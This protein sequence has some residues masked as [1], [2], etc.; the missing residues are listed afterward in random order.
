MAIPE[1]QLDIWSHQ[2]SVAG[3]AATYN[4]LKNTLNDPSA[5]YSEKSY[6]I[7]L[8]GSYGNDTNVFRDSD[9][10]VVIR[11]NDTYYYDHGS[12][13][14]EAKNAFERTRVVATYGFFE[15]RAG[16]LSALQNKFG[17]KVSA[18][19]KAIYIKGEDARRDADVVV[20]TKYRRYRR[21]SN[22]SD[23]QYDEGISL[24][25]TDGTRIENFPKQHSDN[26]TTKHQATSSWFKPMVRIYKNIRNRMVEDNLLQEGIAPSYYIEGMLWNVPNDLYGNSYQSS[27]VNSLNWILHA[28]KSKLACA[29]DLF[30]L[31]RDNS[32][33]CWSN[34]NFDSF[35]TKLR[36]YWN[37]W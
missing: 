5:R 8:Q 11:L 20:C 27:F 18:G 21:N 28:D 16:V 36:D 7:F 17:S 4:L 2:G 9:V 30:W 10:D 22:G 3:S 14:E 29:N 19:S 37:D 23:D 33:V 24:F 34:Q 6:T 31:V 13:T 26:C 35:V 15:F 1:N 25:K 12:L 32:Q